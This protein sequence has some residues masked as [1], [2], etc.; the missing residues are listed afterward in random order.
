MKNSIVQIFLILTFF[1]HSCSQ[2]NRLNRHGYRT[3][4]W[5][6]YLDSAK[7]I[8]SFEGRFRNGNTVGKSYYYTTTGVLER[9]EINRFKVLKTTFYY[10]NKT[11]RLKG[12]ARIDDLSDKI[13][14]YF[15][16]RWKYYDEDGK[17][18]KYC[19][20][21]KGQLV[22]T[23]YIDKNNKVDDSLSVAMSEIDKF[24]LEKNDKLIKKIDACVF[25]SQ[26]CEKFREDLL[27]SDS[28]SFIKIGKIISHYGYPEVSK[29]K[30]ASNIPFFILSYGTIAIKEKYLTILQDAANKGNISWTS[31]A[32]FIDKLKVAKGENQIYGTQYYFDKNRKLIFYPI[33]EKD[34]LNDRRKKIGLS[35]MGD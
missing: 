21:D 31:L 32:F 7:T 34:S 3:G 26:N 17:L 1:I 33:F 19:Y 12:K 4:R 20:Y 9:R 27:K 8:K 15:Y 6:T 23:I 13:H 22:K 14:Y 2:K 35:E 18:S 16:G 5:L 25:H 11:V 28:I 24:F 10:P 29:Y 30:D